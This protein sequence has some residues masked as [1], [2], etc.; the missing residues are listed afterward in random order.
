MQIVAERTPLLEACKLAE[1]AVALRPITQ[2]LSN[3]LLQAEDRCFLT[4]VDRNVGVRVSVPAARIEQSGQALVPAKQF[5]GILRE[6]GEGE[7]TILAQPGRVQVLGKDAEF[8]LRSDEVSRFP[9]FPPCPDG[10]FDELAADALHLA[11][12]RTL[13]A[14]GKEPGGNSFRGALWEIEPDRVRLAATDNRRL[15]VAELSAQKWSDREVPLQALVSLE[16]MQ[17]LERLSAL[18]GGSLQFLFSPQQVFF[19]SAGVILCARLLEGDF[20]PWR[21][22]LS[23]EP[24]YRLLLP[25]G[26]FLSAVR[27][28][29]V[30]RDKADNRLL[31]RFQG[32]RVTLRSRQPGTGQARVQQALVFPCTRE[33]VEVAF[34]P[35]FLLELL[36]VLDSDATVQLDLRDAD[37]PALFRTG[38]NYRH[39]L[40]PLRRE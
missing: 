3:L 32:G 21:K 4:G 38:D 22:A 2:M 1:K 33:P 14:I 28:A 37:S 39:L 31:L 15:A 29:A 7:L 10:P 9:P 6:A 24:R 18:E 16:A 34:N 8:D 23:W 26:A 35:A 11:I 17:L 30:F 13:F 36:D 20:P 27:Q 25:V 5:L 19:R 40:M 12:E